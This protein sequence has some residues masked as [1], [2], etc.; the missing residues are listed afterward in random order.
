MGGRQ[1][2]RVMERI[3]GHG[4]YPGCLLD[5]MDA[6][7]LQQAELQPSQCLFIYKCFQYFRG[8]INSPCVLFPFG[9]E[10]YAI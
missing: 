6:T 10:G 1:A 5:W 4:V 8:T 2:D 7:E 9:Q 3:S